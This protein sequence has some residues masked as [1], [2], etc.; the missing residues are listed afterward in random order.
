[1]ALLAFRGAAISSAIAAVVWLAGLP[2]LALAGAIPGSDAPYAWMGTIGV[3]LG[4]T[5]APGAAVGVR[6]TADPLNDVS[7]GVGLVVCALLV[8][9]GI[10]LR[11]GA[12][13]G[14]GERAPSWVA[15][16]AEIA[17]V[18]L[19]IWILLTSIGAHQASVRGRAMFWLAM[20][21][22]ASL[23]VTIV[24]TA[25]ASYLIPGFVYTNGTILPFLLLGLLIW[26]CPAAWLAIFA[27]RLQE[28]ASRSK[29]PRGI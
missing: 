24:A 22:G 25:L 8:L 1:M 23:L 13:G 2:M 4:L 12:E 19:F 14:L 3:L 20:A 29:L 5:L 15:P 6:R 18:A 7:R 26:L 9:T 11:I 17:W 21:T 10:L 16:A 27:L 28:V